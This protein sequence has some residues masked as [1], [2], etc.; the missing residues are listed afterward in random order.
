MANLPEPCEICAWSEGYW[1]EYPT[2]LGRCKCPRGRA[3]VEVARRANEPPVAKPP[4]ISTEE[5]ELLA[6]MLCGIYGYS[7]VQAMPLIASELRGMC[8][9][10]PQAM[11]FVKRFARLY[12]KWPGGTNELRW[13]YCQMG[14]R[15]L[16]AILPVGDSEIY[17]E[18]LPEAAGG[19][20]APQLEPV[21]DPR[22]R[23]LPPG[24]VGE[25]LRGVIAKSRRF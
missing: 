25:I 13:A 6:E 18:G 12:A 23:D 8:D 3:L 17:P 4:A 20:T 19:R 7:L 9:S 21:P 15:P 24:E 14:F 10:M 22:S 1:V 16:D 2:G 5:A 11:D